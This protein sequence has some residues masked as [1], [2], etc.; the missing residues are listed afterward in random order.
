MKKLFRSNA[1]R[2]ITG[3]CGGLS[4]YI[5]LDATLIRLFFVILTFLTGGSMI[6]FYALAALIV[7][8]DPGYYDIE[9]YSMY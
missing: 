9:K 6:L 1:D 2:K 3:L 7:P 5:G 4:Q 8:K